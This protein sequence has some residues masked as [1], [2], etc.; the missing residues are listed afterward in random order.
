M[1]TSLGNT[2]PPPRERKTGCHGVTSTPFRTRHSLSLLTD[3]LNTATTPLGPFGV[4]TLIPALSLP[5]LIIL[6]EPFSNPAFGAS[7]T[8]EHPAKQGLLDRL[9]ALMRILPW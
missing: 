9:Y 8:M 3:V 7:A 6:A 1:A 4:I 2:H 5:I